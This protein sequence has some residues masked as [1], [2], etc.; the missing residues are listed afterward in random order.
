MIRI[1]LPSVLIAMGPVFGGAQPSAERSSARIVIDAVAFDRSGAPVVDLKPEEMEVW[2]G[3]FRVP[4]ERF[5]A[6][7]PAS[8]QRDGRL[9]VLVLDDV[10]LPLPLASRAQDVARRF[11]NRMQPR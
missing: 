3:H 4:I 2:I 11:V 7:T 10:T 8:D 6:V 5:T 1:L 9:T